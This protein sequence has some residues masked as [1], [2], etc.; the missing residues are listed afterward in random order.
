MKTNVRIGR[1]ASFADSRTLECPFPHFAC[2]ALIAALAMRQEAI[3]VHKNSELKAL[4]DN[5]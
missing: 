5:I 3:L 2:D 4:A 1:R